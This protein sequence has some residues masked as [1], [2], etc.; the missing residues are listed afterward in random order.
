MENRW[1]VHRLEAKI[2][3]KHGGG[4]DRG[5]KVALREVEKSRENQEKYHL[6]NIDP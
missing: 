3:T 6:G 2:G 5:W 1:G 4:G